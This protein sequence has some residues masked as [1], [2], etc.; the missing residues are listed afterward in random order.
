LLVAAAAADRGGRQ[1]A[2]DELLL[3]RSDLLGDGA[4]RVANGI[5]GRVVDVDV[6]QI[7]LVGRNQA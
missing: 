5:R 7:G 6:V 4:K 2:N 3:E 1:R